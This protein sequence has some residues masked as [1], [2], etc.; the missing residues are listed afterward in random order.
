MNAGEINKRL[1]NSVGYYSNLSDAIQKTS[2]PKTQ[3][4]RQ[5]L[6][7]ALIG[8]AI[9]TLEFEAGA[10]G[11]DY[12]PE[13]HI[14]LIDEVIGIMRERVAAHEASKPKTP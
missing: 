5:G 12:S 2:P 10:D 14:P 1:L 8:F 6:M 9:A 13:F 3:E 7:D 11:S 4:Q